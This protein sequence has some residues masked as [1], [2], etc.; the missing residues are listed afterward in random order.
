MLKLWSC[1]NDGM[2][3]WLPQKRQAALENQDFSCMYLPHHQLESVLIL[4]IHDCYCL[5]LAWLSWV[6]LTTTS[7]VKTHM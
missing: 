5:K 2:Q 3:P 7:E 1:H 4:I 6:L